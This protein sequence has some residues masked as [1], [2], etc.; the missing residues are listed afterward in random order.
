MSRQR[1]VVGVSLVVAFLICITTGQALAG[2]MPLAEIQY[3]YQ[4]QPYGDPNHYVHDDLK[5]TT[6]SLSS[7]GGN[8]DASYSAFVNGG[9]APSVGM[10]TTV[11]G[12]NSGFAIASSQYTYYFMVSGPS[13]GT[14]VTVD[15]NYSISY[16]FSGSSYAW[17][18]DASVRINDYTRPD[19]VLD[20]GTFGSGTTTGLGSHV[21]P[22]T[23]LADTWTKVFLIA[24]GNVNPGSPGLSAAVTVLLNQTLALDAD[25]LAGYPGSQ[26]IFS[27]TA[28]PATTVPEPSSLLLLGSGLVGL[29]AIRRKFVE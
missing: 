28:P 13:S 24:E 29:A 2:P 3:R 7:A 16:A 12:A 20:V 25:W 10:T 6:S 22:I 5:S 1:I 8:A 18:A 11:T 9:T 17:A 27:T 26:I 15:L 4:S 19:S 21:D 14:N 23:V